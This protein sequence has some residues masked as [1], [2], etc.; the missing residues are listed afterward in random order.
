M[1]I[2][3][4]SKT[5]GR[6]KKEEKFSVTAASSVQAKIK[7]FSHF[8]LILQACRFDSSLEVNYVSTIYYDY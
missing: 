1:L 6:T 4:Q 8:L 5:E 2:L 3:A 7:T